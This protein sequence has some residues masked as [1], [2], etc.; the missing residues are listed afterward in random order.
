MELTFEDDEKN[1]KNFKHIKESL[2]ELNEVFTVH[3][4]EVILL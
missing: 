4:Y 1:N 3:N 2:S